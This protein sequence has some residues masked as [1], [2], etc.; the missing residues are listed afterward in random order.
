MDHTHTGIEN[1]R[2]MLQSL[3]G[4]NYQFEIQSEKG[5]GT[6]IEITVPTER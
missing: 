6:K 2:R 1:T 3:Y 5:K 4:D